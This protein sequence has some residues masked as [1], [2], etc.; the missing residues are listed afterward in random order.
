MDGWAKNSV[1]FETLKGKIISKIIGLEKGSEQIQFFCEDG[2]KYKL[3]YYDDCCAFCNIEDICGDISDILGNPLLI[4]EEIINSDV[5][6]DIQFQREK[7]NCC[8]LTDSEAWSFYKLSTIKGSVTIRWYGSSNGY[9]SET[10]SFE[11]I[12][13]EDEE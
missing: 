5:P 10:A 8:Y 6:T 2:T 7:E 4:A 3:T 13:D 11:E 9:Y 1:S 12:K